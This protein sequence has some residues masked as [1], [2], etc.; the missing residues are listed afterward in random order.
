MTAVRAVRVAAVSPGSRVGHVFGD[1][2]VD[3]EACR[4]AERVDVGRTR[5][6]T[7]G[8]VEFAA[9]RV[10]GRLELTDD[11]LTAS[12]LLIEAQQFAAGGTVNG[13][14][15]GEPGMPGPCVPGPCVPGPAGEPGAAAGELGA[16][17]SLFWNDGAAS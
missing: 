11:T 5:F 9:D 15:A 13:G 16:D 8:G 14:A 17:G 7:A 3:A 10:R 6:V 1:R 12:D 2:V 4:F